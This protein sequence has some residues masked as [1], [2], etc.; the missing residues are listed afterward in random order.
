MSIAMMRAFLSVQLIYKVKLT[1]RA[2]RCEEKILANFGGDYN[3]II[4]IH[5]ALMRKWCE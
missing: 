5:F 2:L 3:C 4:W 1:G